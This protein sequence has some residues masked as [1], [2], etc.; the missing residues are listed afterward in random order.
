MIVIFQV[1]QR[2][3]IQEIIVVGCE[4]ELRSS[5]VSKSELKVKDPLDPYAITEGRSK[6]EAYYHDHGFDRVGMF[7]SS[8]A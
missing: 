1:V 3:I 8:R 2:P 4:N 6:I 5:L 7:R